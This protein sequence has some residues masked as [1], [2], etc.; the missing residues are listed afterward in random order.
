[1]NSKSFVKL[2]ARLADVKKI[3]VQEAVQILV[4]VIQD[5]EKTAENWRK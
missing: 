5:F 3:S 4:K 2:A 1:M